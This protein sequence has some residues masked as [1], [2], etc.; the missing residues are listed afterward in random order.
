MHA[1][2]CRFVIDVRMVAARPRQRDHH[3]MKAVLAGAVQQ[4][5][6]PP[7][8]L[9]PYLGDQVYLLTPDRYGITLG[10]EHR[11]CRMAEILRSAWIRRPHAVPAPWR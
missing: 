3:L 4:K 7:I 9:F 10:F 11:W 1:R 2:T 5:A 6:R 8:W